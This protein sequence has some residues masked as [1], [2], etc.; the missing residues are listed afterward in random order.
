MSTALLT[1]LDTVTSVTELRAIVGTPSDR[2][3]RKQLA[4]LDVH[5]RAFI[6]RSPFLVLSTA[7]ASGIC[8]ASP[9]GDLPGFVQ[10]LDE[11]TLVIPDRPGNRRAD[12]LSNILDNPHVGLLFLI[13]G[14]DE[15]LRVNGS[16]RIVRDE[17]LLDR[18][19][20]DGRRPQLGIVV[21]V[22]ECYL[23]CAKA[24]L[25]SK[26]WDPERQMPRSEMPSLARMIQDQLRPADRSD[27]EHER[28]V[29]EHARSTAEA[30][31]NLY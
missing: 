21:D 9:K 16:A 24:F 23:H 8:D 13:P 5:C 28:I 4:A 22:E 19:S 6:A 14:M 27:A 15:T 12:S 10:V 2:A 29:D 17:A 30:Y 18:M 26:L 1:G 20:V 25:R 11:H 3:V 7:G 31:C